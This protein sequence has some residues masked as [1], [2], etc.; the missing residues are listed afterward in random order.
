MAQSLAV[1]PDH[2]D[3]DSQY[4]THPGILLA[5]NVLSHSK[6]HLILVLLIWTSTPGFGN[7]V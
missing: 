4:P 5:W 3:K 1:L 7:V 2:R 6:N